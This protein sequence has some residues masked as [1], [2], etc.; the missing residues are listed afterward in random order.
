MRMILSRCLRVQLKKNLCFV[1][2]RGWYKGVGGRVS[3]VL[4]KIR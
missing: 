3:Q 1:M 4:V 2:V